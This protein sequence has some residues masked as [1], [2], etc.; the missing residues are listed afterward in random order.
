[1]VLEISFLEKGISMPKTTRGV[2]QSYPHAPVRRKIA[3]FFFFALITANA[4]EHA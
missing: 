1:M 4:L 2:E 3:D